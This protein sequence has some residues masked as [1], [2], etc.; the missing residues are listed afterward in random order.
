[1]AVI[2]DLAPDERSAR[3]LL[4]FLA[5]P[6]DPITGRVLFR[7]GAVETLRL[8]EDDGT[9]PG[10]NR[11]DAQ[12]WRDRL[13]LPR[14]REDVT[15]KMRGIGQSGITALV[16][17]DEHWPKALNDLGERAPYVLWT[18]GATSFLARPVTDLVTIT[19]ARAATAYGE[20]VA[21][22]LAADLANRGHVIV[23]GGAYGIEGAAHRAA[24]AAGGDTI[25]I[26]AGG[27]DR[28]YPAGHSDLLRRIADVGLLVSELPPGS[29][30]TRHR[31]LARGRVMAALSGAS[32]VAEAG[33]R[34]GSL[35]VAAHA[36]AL[37]RGVGAVP[38]PVTSVAS[39]GPHCLLRDGMAQL[40]TDS[41]DV[42]RLLEQDQASRSKVRRSALGSEFAYRPQHSAEPPGRS[43]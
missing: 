27:V 37:G 8:V 3:M 18:R 12:V 32:V 29:A 35:H 19:G 36:R 21:G 43:L 15:E 23:A 39:A 31:F 17:G 4:S 11:V 1:M 20:H 26:L 7:I 14:R 33:T 30:P 13:A 9:I 24:L 22:D 2:A 16:P 25:A 28:L 41:A 34:S 6:D 5:E 40:V 10:V 42:V 38:G